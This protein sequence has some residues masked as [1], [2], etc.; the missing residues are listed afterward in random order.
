MYKILHLQFG[1]SL[2]VLVHQ[3]SKFDVL[4]VRYCAN[5]IEYLLV[6]VL[7]YEEVQVS[8]G[9][10]LY[11][12]LFVLGFRDHLCYVIELSIPAF[13]GSSMK[14]LVMLFFFMQGLL[15]E[16]CQFDILS[17]INAQLYLCFEPLTLYGDD[18]MLLLSCDGH[19]G[20]Q[21]NWRRSSGY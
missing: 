18:M 7:M 21:R 3:R 11:H 4:Y 6:L 19:G 5:W 20:I 1:F 15:V 2:I 12:V 16:L 9:C 14:M 10:L 13:S 17:R 8:N